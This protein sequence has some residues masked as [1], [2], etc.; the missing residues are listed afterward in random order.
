[1]T[2]TFAGTL[3]ALEIITRLTEQL[4]AFNTLIDKAAAEGRD[5]TAEELKTLQTAD[6]EARTRLQT[7][8]DQAP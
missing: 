6:D 5:I 8:I 4:I 3:A 2:M 1:M 7:L